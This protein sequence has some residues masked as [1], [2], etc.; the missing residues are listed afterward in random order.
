MTENI[1]YI[2]GYI[3]LPTINQYSYFK[4]IESMKEYNFEYKVFPGGFSNSCF[5]G[6]N[7]IL[8]YGNLNKIKDK[9]VLKLIEKRKEIEEINSSISINSPSYFKPPKLEENSKVYYGIRVEIDNNLKKIIEFNKKYLLDKNKGFR[10]ENKKIAI[11]EY[12]LPKEKKKNLEE[13]IEISKSSLNRSGLKILEDE[14]IIIPDL[15]SL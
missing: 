14:L 15:F 2:G 1:K 13:K 11:Y 12:I 4:V 6:S 7:G 5:L 8:F 9:K 3:T 10:L